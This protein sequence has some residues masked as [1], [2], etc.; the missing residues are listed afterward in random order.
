MIAV[1]SSSLASK[2][3]KMVST[4]SMDLFGGY[5]TNNIKKKNLNATHGKNCA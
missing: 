3:N 5:K 2:M 4:D 1:E